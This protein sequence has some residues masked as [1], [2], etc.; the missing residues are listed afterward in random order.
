MAPPVEASAAAGSAGLAP[1][2]ASPVGSWVAAACPA[3][4][5]PAAAWPAASWEPA[6]G[7]WD[8]PASAASP[9]G[10]HCPGRVG[11]RAKAAVVQRAET[12]L[13]RAAGPE[14]LHTAAGRERL[15]TA[16]AGRPSAGDSHS[17]IPVA[18]A[19]RAGPGACQAGPPG[20]ILAAA[21]ACPVARPAATGSVRAAYTAAVPGQLAA[22][23]PAG[24]MAP[25]GPG[26]RPGCAA[27]GPEAGS[28]RYRGCRQRS[29]SRRAWTC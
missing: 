9:G 28:C 20:A 6:P 10:E 8:R 22:A 4:A 5:C 11:M 13:D 29:D 24:C 18:E 16:A 26:E 21:V 19:S 15:D 3:A 27:A 2:T 1:G 14:G 23:G 25:T 17:A 12:G 7:S